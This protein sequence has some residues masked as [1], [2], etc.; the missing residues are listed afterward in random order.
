MIEKTWAEYS[1]RDGET[2]V[3][4]QFEAHGRHKVVGTKI[5]DGDI[6]TAKEKCRLGALLWERDQTTL[7]RA[8]SAV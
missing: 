2:W 6:E 5:V 7:A 3:E 4:L 1:P 8:A